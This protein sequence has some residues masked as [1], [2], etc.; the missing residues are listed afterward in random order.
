DG[1][2]ADRVNIAA[3]FLLSIAF[4]QTGCLVHRMYKAAYGNLPHA[5]V[6][7]RVNEFLPDTQEIS[8]GVVVNQPGWQQV[9]EN[10]MQAFTSGFVQRSRFT[11]AYPASLTPGQLVDS[12]FANTDVTPS[13]AE[14]Q[15][16]IDEFGGAATSADMA[17]RGRAVRRIADNPALVQQEF[18]R[19]FVLMQYL[20]YLRRNPND[21]ADTDY[22]GYDFWV[23]KLNQFNG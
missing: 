14:R 20:V 11:L 4:Q 1:I 5:P 8:R 12:L 7:V 16:A 18:N 2:D 13:A 9:L 19:A 22:A 21:A 6:P 3:A 17:A 10:N 15:A 23:Q